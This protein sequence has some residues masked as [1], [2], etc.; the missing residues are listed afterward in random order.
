MVS[1]LVHQHVYLAGSFVNKLSGNGI[2]DA[3]TET[4]W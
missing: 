4:K 1:V 2:G 3:V